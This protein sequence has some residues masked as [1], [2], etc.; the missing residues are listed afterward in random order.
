MILPSPWLAGPSVGVAQNLLRAY[1]ALSVTMALSNQH[2]P[3]YCIPFPRLPHRTYARAGTRLLALLRRRTCEGQRRT[4]YTRRGELRHR[5]PACARQTPFARFA[6]R[7]I[8]RLCI[9]SCL[10]RWTWTGLGVLW[11]MQHGMATMQH[12]DRIGRKEDRDRR[13]RDRFGCLHFHALLCLYLLPTMMLGTFHTP[14]L[15][16][17]GYTHFLPLHTAPGH[18]HMPPFYYPTLPFSFPWLLLLALYQ[19]P[20]RDASPTLP[21]LAMPATPALPHALPLPA[22]H[23]NIVA[24][25]VNVIKHAA[26]R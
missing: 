20:S 7:A 13:D 3:A 25:G 26:P 5:P 14:A 2:A 16:W 15:T 17:H 11:D 21:C 23:N 22:N 6:A 12:A 18:T 4:S 19:Y 8:S 24:F 10:Y 9:N 1:G